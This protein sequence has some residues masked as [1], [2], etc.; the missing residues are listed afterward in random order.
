DLLL[1]DLHMPGMDGFQVIERIR[2]REHGT[3]RRLFVVALTAR[4]R[5]EDRE[6]CLAAGM[7]G[8]LVKPLNS[9]ALWAELE[10]VS[11]ADRWLDAAAMLAACGGEAAILDSLKASLRTW[12][13]EILR[14]TQESVRHGDAR[15]LREAAH[16]LLGA[17]ATV[18]SSAARLA[19]ALENAAE[20]GELNS[21][22]AL[23]GE[24]EKEVDV[25]LARIGAVT[26]ERLAALTG[27]PAP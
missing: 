24:L 7:D 4:S 18:S 19:S 27:N 8:Y 14:R 13:P 22:A 9:L 21:A 10:R 23:V 17:V 16:S 12:L 15:A 3:G 1:L 25:I 20:V 2:A 6:R 11:G 26:L 5:A